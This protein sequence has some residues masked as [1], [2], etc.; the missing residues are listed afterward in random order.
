MQAAKDAVGQIGA[1]WVSLLH[2]KLPSGVEV[3][4]E[5]VDP[6]QWSHVVWESLRRSA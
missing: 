4:L 1:V 3:H 2:I 5:V 6:G